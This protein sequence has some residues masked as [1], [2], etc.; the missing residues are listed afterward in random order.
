MNQHIKKEEIFAY[1]VTIQSGIF[2]FFEQKNLSW[3]SF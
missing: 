1:D 2:K 3:G